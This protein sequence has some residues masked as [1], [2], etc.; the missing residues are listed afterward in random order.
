MFS[1]SALQNCYSGNYLKE[2]L[3]HFSK[4][5]EGL[6]PIIGECFVWRNQIKLSLSFSGFNST[7]NSSSLDCLSLIVQS[8]SSSEALHSPQSSPNPN[9]INHIQKQL[10]QTTMQ[11]HL[12][13]AL[14]FK[15]EVDS[16]LN[17][18]FVTRTAKE[19]NVWKCE[20]ETR[21]FLLVR[22]WIN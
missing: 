18:R 16:K 12:N 13:S 22:I 19:E 1:S 11:H 10:N 21:E 7:L 8:I 9:A 6:T 14:H 17:W 3:Q 15:C 20:E 5:S 4:D 2:R